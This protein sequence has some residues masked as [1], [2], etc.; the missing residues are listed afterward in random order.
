MKTHEIEFK[1]LVLLV[2]GTYYN[3]TFGTLEQPPEPEE[4]EIDKIELGLSRHN[5]TELFEM[6]MDDIE[7]L[8]IERH[9]R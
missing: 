2:T 4:F 5:L 3:S 8:I 7:N 6:F 9:Y 1:G